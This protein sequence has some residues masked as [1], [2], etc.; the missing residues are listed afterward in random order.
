M[1]QSL[2]VAVVLAVSFPFTVKCFQTP[3]LLRGSAVR[4]FQTAR[5]PCGSGFP[6]RFLTI[7]MNSAQSAFDATDGIDDWI[8]RSALKAQQLEHAKN[9]KV[10]VFTSEYAE[11]RNQEGTVVRPS[12]MRGSSVALYF[13]SAGC[14]Q[15]KDFTT[16]LRAYFDAHN[17]HCGD[18]PKMN[19][20]FV[21][22]DGTESE[23]TSHFN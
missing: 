11:L 6:V 8:T 12:L 10:D 22:C 17:T 3:M 2:L 19:V 20:V 16:S 7:A 15:C 21:S 13:A 5:V 14:D 1:R 9:L 18:D 23:A 4:S